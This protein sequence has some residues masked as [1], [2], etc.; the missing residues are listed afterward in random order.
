MQRNTYRWQPKREFWETIL[1]CT[2]TYCHERIQIDRNGSKRR[3]ATPPSSGPSFQPFICLPDVSFRQI[4]QNQSN[5]C[6]CALKS[7]RAASL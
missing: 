5:L 6:I 1:K 4:L 2:V 7:W 3:N